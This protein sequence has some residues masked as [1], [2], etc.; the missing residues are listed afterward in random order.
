[1]KLHV[2]KYGQ[3]Q[4]HLVILHGL[5]GTADNW[6]LIAQA[7]SS[8]YHVWVPD[9]RNHGRSPHHP[10]IGYADFVDDIVKNLADDGITQIKLIGHSMGGK[11]AMQMALQMPELIQKLVV[12]DMA[13]RAYVRGHDYIFKALFSLPISEIKKRQEAEQHLAQFGFS[14]AVIQFLLKNL[15]RKPEGGFY[16][17]PN[18]NYLF[19]GYDEIT[20]EIHGPS[21]GI[22]ALFLSGENSQYVKA[23]DWNQI[24]QL[25]PKALGWVLPNTDHWLHAEN[26][27]GFLEVTESFL[28]GQAISGPG[29]FFPV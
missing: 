27:K 10:T 8:H 21:I 29:W 1:M 24:H 2:N 19:Q 23:E 3:G 25:F 16:W 4:E 11:V 14:D 5:L 20:R 9:L 26:P 7:F 17:K 13:P 22:D 18:L 12:V 6:H 15:G 28:E